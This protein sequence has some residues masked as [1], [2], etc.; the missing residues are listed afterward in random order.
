MLPALSFSRFSR[1]LIDCLS[2]DLKYIDFGV[3]IKNQF[4]LCY[5]YTFCDNINDDITLEAIDKKNVDAEV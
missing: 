4:N 2:C 3:P 5:R 1:Q